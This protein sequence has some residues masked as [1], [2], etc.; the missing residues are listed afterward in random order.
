MAFYINRSK[1]HPSSEAFGGED[2]LDGM[3]IVLHALTICS[4]L[5]H[6]IDDR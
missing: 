2:V 6:V 3:N 1:K 4:F 5:Y